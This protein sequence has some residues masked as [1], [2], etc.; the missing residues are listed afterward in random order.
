MDPRIY[1]ISV[2]AGLLVYGLFGLDFEIDWPQMAVSLGGVLLTQWACTRL[3][4]LPRF[5]VRSALISGLSLCLLLR[6]NYLTLALVAAVIT[7]ASKFVL[8]WRG[9]HLFN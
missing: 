1:Q 6:T 7:I 4:K 9:K 5:E 2:L 3:W 8:G